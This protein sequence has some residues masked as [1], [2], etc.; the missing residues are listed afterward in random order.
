MILK[1][2]P[3][4]DNYFK[5]I[6]IKNIEENFDNDYNLNDLV[7]L[8]KER[9]YDINGFEPSFLKLLRNSK[10]YLNNKIIKESNKI[11]NAI[12]SIYEI[13]QNKVNILKNLYQKLLPPND[14]DLFSVFNCKYLKRDLYILIDK[15]ESNLNY[16]IYK[17][18][19]YILI[20][21]ITTFLSIF[22]SIYS[23]KLKKV[24]FRLNDSIFKP[25]EKDEKT[26]ISEKPKIGTIKEKINLEE[27]MKSSLNEK[28][29]LKKKIKHKNKDNNIVN[30]KNH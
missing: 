15:L 11:K 6:K 13:F 8:F 19:V 5:G 20:F 30:E 27:G 26:D 21:G 25:N 29:G 22:L 16:S 23:I 9:Y 10:E 1:D 17:L 18:T 28:A 3:G 14:T 12:I 7:N 2:F 4:Q 24:D